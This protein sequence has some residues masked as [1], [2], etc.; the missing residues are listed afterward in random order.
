MLFPELQTPTLS[1]TAES[2]EASE[3][4]GG[5]LSSRA[6][7]STCTCARLSRFA[8]LSYTSAHARRRPRPLMYRG[9]WVVEVPEIHVI[10]ESVDIEPMLSREA[11]VSGEGQSLA[12]LEQWQLGGLDLLAIRKSATEVSRQTSWSLVL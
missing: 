2:R 8:F 3:S 1:A 10:R 11:P 9:V 4:P 7:D 12:V 6:G 5:L